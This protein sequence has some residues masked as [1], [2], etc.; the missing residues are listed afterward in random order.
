MSLESLGSREMGRFK[1][2]CLTSSIT[3]KLDVSSM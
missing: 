2:E 3:V 1:K